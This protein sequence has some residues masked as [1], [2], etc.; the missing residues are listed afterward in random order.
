MHVARP[1]TKTVGKCTVHG[2]KRKV[3][4]GTRRKAQGPGS[5]SVNLEPCAVCHFGYSGF[6]TMKELF[7]REGE[8]HVT[9]H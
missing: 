3:R 7:E 9:D 2:I 4:D 8:S 6:L 1:A 5:L